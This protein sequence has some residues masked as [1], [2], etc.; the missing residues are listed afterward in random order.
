MNP[1]WLCRVRKR[2]SR[3][4]EGNPLPIRHPLD[5][6]ELGQLRSATIAAAAAVGLLTAI[7]FSSVSV[8][9]LSRIEELLGAS[10]SSAALALLTS[11]P[12]S[13]FQA[14]SF[15]LGFDLLYDLVHN[16]AVALFAIWGARRL[17]TPGAQIIGSL[18]AWVMWLDSVLN[19]FENL[20]FLHVIRTFELPSLVP[21]ASTVF[22]FRS[23]TLVTGLI[24]A[25]A[26]HVLAFR[27]PHDFAKSA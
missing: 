2:P 10:S 26:L 16:N 21:I 14:F 3:Q 24:V 8:E 1:A 19:V 15:M 9:D 12:Q 7:L 17:S 13:T 18:V 5:R 23:A 20:A 27:R 4:T 22:T 6:L 11:W 25:I